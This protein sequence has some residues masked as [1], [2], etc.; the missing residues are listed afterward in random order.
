MS[1]PALSRCCYV[2][3]GLQWHGSP[4]AGQPSPH[5]SRT[6]PVLTACH[7]CTAGRHQ[8]SP[9]PAYLCCGSLLSSP[10]QSANNP[11]TTG[12]QALS[13]ADRL[14]PPGAWPSAAPGRALWPAPWWLT[15]A[16][17][18]R[19]APGRPRP[20]PGATQGGMGGT[21]LARARGTPS[22]RAT[23]NRGDARRRQWE[24]R[25]GLEARLRAKR[26]GVLGQPPAVEEGP[27]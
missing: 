27:R 2:V 15:P 16:R 22:H 26:P 4:P 5:L 6:R 12:G 19:P 25:G 24:G 18:R 7:P 21:L 20:Q 9:C 11:A 13:S 17:P 8:P 14:Q 10:A 3:M 23:R 1:L